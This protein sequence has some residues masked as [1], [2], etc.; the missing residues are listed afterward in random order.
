MLSIANNS[1]TS[2]HNGGQLQYGPDGYLYW[3][4]GEDANPANAATL[5]NLLGKILRIDPRGNAAGRLHIA[6]RQPVRRRSRCP[7]RGLGLGAAQPVAL[8]V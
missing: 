6:A 3:S 4:T 1:A 7:A 8:L 2:N 5:T